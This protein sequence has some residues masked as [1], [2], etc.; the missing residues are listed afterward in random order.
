[1][2]DIHEEPAPVEPVAAEPAPVEPAAAEPEAQPATVPLSALNESRAQQRQTQNELN[3]MREQ[4]KTFE[5][6][7]G[8]LDEYRNQQVQSNQETEFNQDPLG[9]MQKQIKDLSDAIQTRDQNADQSQA[10][11]NQQQQL[12]NMVATQVQEF[13]TQTPDY[14]EALAHVME[15]RKSELQ[16]LGM[17]ENQIQAALAQHAEEL[18]HTALQTGQNPGKLVYD[19]AKLRGYEA[20]QTAAKLAAVAKGQDAASTLAGT[21]GTEDDLGSLGDIASMSDEDFD[22]AWGEMEKS[23]KQSTH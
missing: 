7:R 12:T 11:Q 9:V 19:L 3:Q 5:G 17:A 16:V 4:M 6:L 14:D 23:Q 8:E 22:K 13:R 18:A 20:K 1:M 2:S 10:Q 15:A 21:S